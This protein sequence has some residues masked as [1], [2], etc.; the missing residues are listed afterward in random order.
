MRLDLTMVPSFFWGK[1]TWGFWRLP[2]FARM[3]SFMLWV[4]PCVILLCLGPAR[5]ALKVIFAAMMVIS[6]FRQ[7]VAFCVSNISALS[8]FRFDGE[9]GIPILWKLIFK[10]LGVLKC[11]SL[12]VR[13]TQVGLAQWRKAG[14]KWET[15]PSNPDAY[16]APAMCWHGAR[17]ILCM[18]LVNLTP[19][20]IWK[21]RTN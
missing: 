4:K 10:G 1:G 11:P 13:R 8:I 7:R 5:S 12:N 6:P 9:P 2:P 14:P 16:W 3:A 19:R 20:V 15:L 21:L 18:I 17:C